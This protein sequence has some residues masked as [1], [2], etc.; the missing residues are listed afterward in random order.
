LPGISVV[1]IAQPVA[2]DAASARL[3]PLRLQVPVDAG[4]GSAEL[5]PGTHKIEFIIQAQDD[6]KVVRHE[7]SSFIIP[8]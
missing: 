4:S 3:L 8:R 1:G 6:E 7:Q 5:Q 2:L